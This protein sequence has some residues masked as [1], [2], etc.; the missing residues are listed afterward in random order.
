MRKT[1]NIIGTSS[2]IPHLSYLRRETQQRFTLIELL[3]VIAIIAILAGMLLPALN[4]AK[5]K[6]VAVQCMGNMRQIGQARLNYRLDQ[7]NWITPQF[8]YYQYGSGS[9]SIQYWHLILILNDYLSNKNQSAYIN[10]TSGVYVFGKYPVGVF[11]CPSGENKIYDGTAKSGDSTDYG[12]MRYT[13]NIEEKSSSG[14]TSSAWK[15]GFH[16]DTEIK[17][18]IS[19]V[20]MIMDSPRDRK[21]TLSGDEADT[22]EYVYPKSFRHSKGIN[23]IFM[24]GHGAWTHYKKVPLKPHTTPNA[25]RYAFWGRKDFMLSDWGKYKDL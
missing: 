10:K 2:L 19:K 4:Q 11:R 5:Q 18:D 23:V 21:V 14:T 8:M 17:K 9:T 15:R 25:L 3:V 12:T 7:K 16:L 24:D 6:A 22:D 13:G 1:E 20:M